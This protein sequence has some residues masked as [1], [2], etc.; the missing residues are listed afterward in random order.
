[1]GLNTEIGFYKD[2]ESIFSDTE[3]I[4]TFM[5]DKIDPIEVFNL[6]DISDFSEV[7]MDFRVGII[8]KYIY[9][10]HYIL[11]IVLRTIDNQSRIFLRNINF[12][13]KNVGKE[14][15]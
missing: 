15:N 10:Q 7:W 9:K 4:S 8:S 6:L 5:E 12:F 3:N 13:Q 14:G 11:K 2:K 1:M